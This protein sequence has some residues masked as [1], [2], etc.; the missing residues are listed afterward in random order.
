MYSIYQLTLIEEWH[1]A[2][3]ISYANN[4]RRY[5]LHRHHGPRSFQKKE[6]M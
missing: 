1:D 5:T 6:E 4:L 2:L 3:G